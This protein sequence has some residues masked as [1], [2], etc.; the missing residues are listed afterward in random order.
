[1][2]D[3][4]AARTFCDQLRGA[5][6]NALGDAEAFDQIIHSVE[7]LGSFLYGSIGDLGKYK[8]DL[9]ELASHSPLAEDISTRWP[10]SHLP[11]SSLY[12]LVRDA[13]NDALHQGAFARHLTRNAIKLSLIL[14]DALKSMFD[15]GTAGDYMVHPVQVAELWQPI[16]FIRQLM[17]ANSFSHLPVKTADE[18]WCFVSDLCITQY[19]RAELN[20]RKVRLAVALKE[21]AIGVPLQPA[22]WCTIDASLAEALRDLDGLPLLVSGKDGNHNVPIGILTAFDLL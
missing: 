4:R 3:P 16:S 7:R 6:E 12:E 2:E 22:N 19:L 8:Q 11:F 5:R 10:G 1:M 15:F 17:L 18:T 21:T 20:S 9:K 14:E 13:R